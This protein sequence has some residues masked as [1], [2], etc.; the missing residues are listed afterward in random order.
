M[1]Q[2]DGITLHFGERALFDNI[3]TIINPG[4]RIGLVG[5]N[6]AG[7]STLLKIIAGEQQADSGSIS[8][9]NEATVGYLPQDGVEPDP[10]LTVFEEVEHAFSEIMKL[11]DQFDT[12][13][14]KMESVAADSAEHEEAL[15]QFGEIQHKL[16]N[17]GSYTLQAEIERILAG[18]G[19]DE[20]DFIRSTTEFSGGWLMRI[21]LAKLLLRQP[22][23]LL[24]DEPTNHLDIE[25]LQWIETFLRNYDGAVIIVSHDRAFLDNVTTRTLALS[26]GSLDDYAGNYTFYE[27][28]YAKEKELLKQQFEN[29]QKEIKQ[30]QEFID[31]FRYKATKAK[32]VQSRIKQLEK[33]EQIE[34]EQEQSEISFHFPPAARSGQ[35]V[36]K[37]ENVVK[38][39]G[40]NTV[41]D[42]LDYEI[43]R[44]DKIA[45][46][47]PNGA[48]KSTMIRILAGLEPI[49]D[50][51]RKVGY[52]VTPG[53][54]AQHQAEELEPKNTPLDEMRL[55]GSN[56]SE[57]KL[58][59]IL[60]SFLFV[61][62]DVFKKVSVLS[63][64]EKS[65]VAL[66]K[67]LLSDGNFLIFD[68]PTNH[69]DMQSKEILQQ[70][71]QQF[72]GTLMIVSHDRHFLDPI[73]N[74][75]LEVQPGRIKTWLGNVSYY[76]D[77]KALEENSPDAQPER[78]KNGSSAQSN[79]DGLSRKEQRRLEAEK[80]N[81]L[82]KKIKPLKKRLQEIEKEIQ[83]H[84][85]RIS[86]IESM[87]AETDFYDDSEKVKK[88]SLEY[89]ELKHELGQSFNKWEE[90]AGRIEFIEEEYES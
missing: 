72:E 87:M 13:Q 18:L 81:A 3:N 9:S 6:G 31:R 48:G 88:V 11:R 53:Y 17:S 22:T 57:T 74:K 20:E 60:G 77:K 76:L 71:L 2:I 23:Y 12:V 63:G 82:S 78:S 8:M 27:K 50:G 80:R 46:V 40:D 5:P 35:V 10:D 19:F 29:Q 52:N 56:E 65:R 66:A 14:A 28:K 67:M 61:G 47:G 62:D 64:G 15:Q 68:E 90:I 58:R 43:E 25:S 37:L 34:L 89:E 21:A 45:V 49:T 73:V 69:L 84:E 7:K 1:L 54:F 16:E 38:K 30:T 32:Q 55:A 41:F 26:R 75:T 24:L 42:G 36:M 86:E 44:G 85:N 59:T 79:T 39:Y 70:A 4:E 83:T 51:E 33:M